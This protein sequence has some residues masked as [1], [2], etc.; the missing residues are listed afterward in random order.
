MSHPF[1]NKIF[2]L[3]GSPERCSRR[4]VYEALAAVGGI[5]DDR[6]STFT[7]YVVEFKHNGKTKKYAKALE[8]NKKG[9]L[10]LLN[11][12]QLFDIIDGKAKAPVRPDFG[13]DMEVLQPLKKHEAYTR[14]Q[15]KEW[16]D[17]LNHKRMS[18]MAKYG[19][20]MPDGSIAKI[21]LRP[22]DLTRRLLELM[23]KHPDQYGFV[24]PSTPY[25]YCNVCGRSA[26]VHIRAD[27]DSEYIKLCQDCYNEMM[28]EFTG[29]EMPEFI[30]E[31]FMCDD[32]SGKSHKFNIEFL[33]FATGKDLTAKEIGKSKR[34]IQVHGELDADVGAMLQL[35]KRKIIKAINTKHIDESG[36]IN[37]GIAEGY[38]EYNSKR[39]DHDVI[40]DGKPF[41]WEEL[42]KNISS[43]EGWN[44][45]IELNDVDD[46]VE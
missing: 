16:N 22:L 39:K 12:V 15:E 33:I 19:V 10:I 8:D 32:E 14:Q 36:Y 46:I 4:D 2:A 9:Y 29:T 1:E 27:K 40:I 38:I 35:L 20:T 18:N 34:R 21:D 25:E 7:E 17:L 11:E 28:A 30:P 45:R 31:Q 42:K 23:K 41:T 44:I 24:I 6:I 43:H 5:I 37:N 26:K 3:I 13:K